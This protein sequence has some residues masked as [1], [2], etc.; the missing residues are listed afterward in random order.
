MQYDDF[1]K[2]EK[3]VKMKRY[4]ITAVLIIFSA[5]VFSQVTANKELK[6]LI[7]SSFSYHP[8][9][10]EALN[11]IEIAQQGLNL[12]KTNLPD[13]DGEASY[14]YIQPKITLPFP[15][16][17]ETVNFQFAPVNAYD[18]HVGA[19]YVLLDFGRLKA[20]IDKSKS[21]LKYSIDNVENVQTQL[22]SQ[23]STVYY[24]IIYLRKAIT[25][26]D[27]VLNYLNSNKKIAQDRLNNGDAIKLDVL[28]I[29]SQIDAEQNHRA[30]LV[31]NLQKQITLL[32]YTSGITNVS[33]TAFDFTVPIQP[34][35]DALAAAQTS[36]PDFIL[37][38]DRVEQAKADLA[39]AKLTGKPSLTAGANL[40]VKN[41]YVPDVNQPRF[42]YAAGVTLKVPIYHAKTKKQIS[43]AE[44]QVKQTQLSQETLSN[45]YEKNIEQAL[46][47]IKTN[48]EKIN[49]MQSQIQTAVS[50]EQIAASRY[51]NG[52]GLNKDITD[53]AVN[54]ERAQLTQLQYEYQ[55]C[56]AKVE[57]ARLTGV[58]YW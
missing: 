25:V 20:A 26:E 33:D 6:G 22:A 54:L 4:L 44:S 11:Q 7:N 18:A 14:T 43:I 53:A 13:V 29:Q 56:L 42:N 48:T 10:K 49:N 55:L 12:A 34:T 36:V 23:V 16:N 5:S 30:D 38:Q 31:N 2:K 8:R 58:K 50:A 3:F 40:G 52:I 17:G 41:G 19:N 1:I 15:I 21:N 24:N 51:L 39:I 27:S 32:Q 47:D 9:V 37:A 35:T 46:T 57:F 28:N 45:E